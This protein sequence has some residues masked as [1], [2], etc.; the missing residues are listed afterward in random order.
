MYAFI[1]LQITFIFYASRA[2]RG[3]AAPPEPD[4]PAPLAPMLAPGSALSFSPVSPK[5]DPSQ[6]EPTLDTARTIG[7]ARAEQTCVSKTRSLNRDSFDVPVP[8]ALVLRLMRCDTQG[9]RGASTLSQE[10]SATPV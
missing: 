8:V 1:I 4:R 5:Q 2:P 10:Q 3:G 9:A 6:P 7:E